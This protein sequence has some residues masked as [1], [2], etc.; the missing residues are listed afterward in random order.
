MAS[1]GRLQST[2]SAHMEGYLVYTKP[3]N[4]QKESKSRFTLMLITKFDKLFYQLLSKFTLISMKIKWLTFSPTLIPFWCKTTISFYCF[5]NVL[6]GLPSNR[7]H[8]IFNHFGSMKKTHLCIALDQILR[9]LE[10]YMVN[11]EEWRVPSIRLCTIR[12]SVFVRRSSLLYS[13]LPVLL[14]HLARPTN[15]R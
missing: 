4:L 12:K 8:L 13:G 5:S 6:C 15:Y 9:K 3:S 14:V 10:L 2:G 7:K 11:I 1:F